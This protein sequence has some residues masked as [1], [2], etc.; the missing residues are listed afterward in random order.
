[1]PLNHKAE[2]WMQVLRQL[3]YTVGQVKKG[4]TAH[5]IARRAYLQALKD[6]QHEE[7]EKRY[8]G[9]SVWEDVKDWSKGLK[10]KSGV[11]TSQGYSTKE[12]AAERHAALDK[13]AKRSGR[14]KTAARLQLVANLSGKKPV[15]RVLAADARY[16][17]AH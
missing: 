5:K 11:L 15:G 16:V 3:N 17:R 8:S 4:T 9:G 7:D 6:L 1:M 10:L 14:K 13:I 12:P 2:L